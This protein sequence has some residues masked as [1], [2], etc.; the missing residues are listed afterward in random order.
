[1][2]G[3]PENCQKSSDARN[4]LRKTS[5]EAVEKKPS[6]AK[7]QQLTFRQSLQVGRR[8]N[9]GHDVRSAGSQS[10]DNG[11]GR[12]ATQAAGRVERIDAKE[13]VDEA[14]RDAKHRRTAVLPGVDNLFIL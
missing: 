10:S 9:A 11:R 1:M 8:L 12:S 2:D 4:E 7:N 6:S 13:L 5:S 14:A 3:K